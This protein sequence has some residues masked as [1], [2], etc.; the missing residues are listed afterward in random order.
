[1]I[2][3]HECPGKPLQTFQQRSESFTAAGPYLWKTSGTFVL[4]GLMICLHY[5]LPT[6]SI[7]DALKDSRSLK[8][9]RGF[10]CHGAEVPLGSLRK[11]VFM[12]VMCSLTRSY[13]RCIRLAD[14]NLSTSLSTNICSLRHKKIVVTSMEWFFFFTASF[15][16][17]VL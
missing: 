1:M 12:T 5:S 13:W 4:N 15:F 3:S 11:S 8:G 17:F 10:C 6:C 9:P 7:E 2:A 16:F 14:S